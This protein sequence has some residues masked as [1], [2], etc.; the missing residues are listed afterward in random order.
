[1][2]MLEQNYNHFWWVY[3]KNKNRF[4]AQGVLGQYILIS[5]D[6]ETVIVRLGNGENT[7]MWPMLL[8]DLADRLNTDVLNT[9]ITAGQ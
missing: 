6:D 3:P 1:M 2:D 9:N 4:A 7:A 8:L 5:P